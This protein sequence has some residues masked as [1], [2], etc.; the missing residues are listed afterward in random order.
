MYELSQQE[1]EQVIS[2]YEAWQ[3]QTSPEYSF[4]MFIEWI[5]EQLENNTDEYIQALDNIV[6]AL[7]RNYDEA[8]REGDDEYINERIAGWE[9]A[10]N[11]I[12]ELKELHLEKE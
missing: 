8:D 6:E 7:D 5:G 3:E 11:T 4:D 9:N 12:K 2:V 1:Q 10:K